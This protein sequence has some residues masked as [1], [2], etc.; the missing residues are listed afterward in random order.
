MTMT[1]E[2]NTKDLKAAFQKCLEADGPYENDE[3]KSICRRMV[4]KVPDDLVE[5]AANTSYAYWYL[6]QAPDSTPSEET[7]I[8]M[9]M[10]EARRHL[11]Y[12]SGDYETAFKNFVE[13]CEYRK[14]RDFGCCCVCEVDS[15]SSR[16]DKVFNIVLYCFGSS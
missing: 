1:L 9:A 2:E 5:H 4:E 13:S 12:M 3:Q 7:K 6:A 11:T 10:R 16:E 15:H 14:V 8:C